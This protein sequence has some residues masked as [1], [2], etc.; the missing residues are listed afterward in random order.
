MKT[1]MVVRAVVM[2]LGLAGLAVSSPA[3]F[4]TL[5]NSDTG[6]SSSFNTAGNW[7]CGAPPSS[8]NDYAM[9]PNNGASLQTPSAPGN[10]TFAGDSLTISNNVG[11]AFKGGNGDTITVNNLTLV[12]GIVRNA[13]ATNTTFTLAGSLTLDNG[14]GTGGKFSAQG[15]AT[16]GLM[17]SATIGSTA[18]S[19]LVITA[20]GGTAGPGGTV[21]L[22]GTNTYSGRTI[23]Q[24]GTLVVESLNSVAGGVAGSNLGHPTTAANGAIAIGNSTVTTVLRY[25]GAG[26]TTDRAINLTGTTGG[27]TIEQAGSGLLKFTG[28]NTAS[29][30]GSKTLT[31]QGSSAGS[32]EIA[33]PIV[34]NTAS[35]R[36]AL[37]K[38]GTGK[39][40]LSATN[41]YTGP[42][43]IN[44]GTLAL[45]AG[46]S[47]GASAVTVAAN[48]TLASVATTPVAI[49]GAVTLQAGAGLAFVAAG[50][51]SAVGRIS[52][53]GNLALNG[54]AVTVAVSGAE[55]APGTYRLMD[56][57][58]TLTSTGALGTLTVV[59]AGIRGQ[60]TL[61]VT[62]GA[63]GHVDLVVSPATAMRLTVW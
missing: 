55:L 1:P 41:T 3:A 36:T 6:T 45:G 58:G 61:S 7:S 43:A 52:V 8:G 20:D 27:A 62:A 40:M 12:Q 26:E 28:T 32:G 38:S 23:I 15:D 13:S 14:T 49:G 21:R 46:G 4:C 47:I 17:V 33:G 57:A 5:T 11:L 29:G 18:A 35:N 25:I 19:T 51:E 30:A 9:I 10:Y 31:L 48:A 2:A 42:T 50:D 37:V 44:G 56:C 53:A 54:N 34:N 16:K 24:S 39:W 63:A 60:A 59:G 22:M